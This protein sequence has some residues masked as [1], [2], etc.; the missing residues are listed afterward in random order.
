MLIPSRFAVSVTPSTDHRVFFLK[1]DPSREELR[2][3]AYVLFDVQSKYIDGGLPRRAIKKI[4]CAGGD[5]ISMRGET[6]YCNGRE[7]AIAKTH[8]IA[9]EKLPRFFHSGKTPEDR[10]FVAG[11]H[12]DSYDSRYFGFIKK[13]DVKALA[14]PLF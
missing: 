11:Q 2:K 12:R 8:S 9:S 7:I 5:E 13:E 3:G 4:A 6:F 10:I 14:Y 1:Q